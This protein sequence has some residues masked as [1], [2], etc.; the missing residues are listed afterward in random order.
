[1][2]R[3]AILLMLFALDGCL[4]DQSRDMAACRM[5]ADRFY[6]MYNAIDPDDPSSKYVLACMANKGY[7]YTIL[8]QD[9]D[10][11]YPSSTQAACYEPDSWLGWV[12]DHFRHALKSD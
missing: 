8:S 2:K 6:H 5:Q 12:T 1:M 3:Q 9:C 10:S 7:N 4:P 11:R